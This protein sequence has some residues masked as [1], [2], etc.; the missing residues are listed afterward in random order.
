MTARVAAQLR[1]LSDFDVAQYGPRSHGD[2]IPDIM[3]ADRLE[4]LRSALV[5]ILTIGLSADIADD[6]PC[7]QRVN[8]ISESFTSAAASLRTHTLCNMGH[9]SSRG[10]RR[11]ISDMVNGD[12]RLWV[13]QLMRDA[14]QAKP[15]EVRPP[16]GTVFDMPPL[17]AL[18]L[19]HI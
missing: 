1:S 7:L 14:Q 11:V 12:L 13:S 19:I 5:A 8:T 15:A 9:L 6:V 18:S 4:C 10:A 17:P 16:P 2:F 3:I